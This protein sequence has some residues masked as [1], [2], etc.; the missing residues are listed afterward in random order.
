[1]LTAW[2]C[3]LETSVRNFK[4]LLDDQLICNAYSNFSSCKLQVNRISPLKELLPIRSLPCSEPIVVFYYNL[5]ASLQFVVNSYEG[6]SLGFCERIWVRQ[7]ARIVR[8]VADP[9]TSINSLS[10][11]RGLH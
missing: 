9:K 1:M 2:A 6:I 10:F 7:F 8:I 3:P 4:A 5:S 11:W